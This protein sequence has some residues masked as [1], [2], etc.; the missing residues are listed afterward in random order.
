MGDHAA[1]TRH[2]VTRRIQRTI[3]SCLSSQNA[4]V[5]PVPGHMIQLKPFL[6]RFITFLLWTP[7]WTDNQSGRAARSLHVAALSQDESRS[8]P[9]TGPQHLIWNT[10]LYQIHTLISVFTYY[11]QVFSSPF[12]PFKQASLSIK[13]KNSLLSRFYIMYIR[14]KCTYV[15]I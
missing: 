11:L 13:I 15:V 6:T 2:H 7:Q 5:F 12:S 4:P 3:P 1:L 9:P 14:N 10:I 8:V